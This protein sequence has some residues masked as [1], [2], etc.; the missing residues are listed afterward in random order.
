MDLKNLDKILESEPRFRLKQINKLIYKDLVDDWASASVLPRALKKTLESETALNIDAKIFKSPDGKTLKALITL[1][2]GLKIET[3][4]MRS[5]GD[6]NSVCVSCQVG[7]PLGCTFCATGKMGFKRNLETEEI[8]EQV[9]LFARILKKEGQKVTSVV[10]M[11]MGEPF[12]NYENVADSIKILNDS[13][14]FN[15]GARRISVSTAGIPQFIKKFA[16]D[17]PECNLAISLHAANA[18]LRSQLMP[19]NNAY[20]LVGLLKAVDDYLTITNRKVMLEYVLIDGVN[21]SESNALEL[22]EIAKDRLVHVNLIPYNPTG[23]FSPSTKENINK[24][25]RVLNSKNVSFTERFH[26]GTDINAACGQLA[27]KNR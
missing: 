17:F 19:I 23:V 3:V 14:K 4:L 2:D 9:V 16:L 7:C 6:R 12:L 25:K 21:D 11:G 15:L 5:K 13:E 8:V 1:S 18:Y 26:F 20:P 10:Y 22:A 24:F 27:L